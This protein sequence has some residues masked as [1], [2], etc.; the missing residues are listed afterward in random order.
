M[1]AR[2]LSSVELTLYRQLLE[3]V[4]AEMGRVLQHSSYSPNIKERRDFSC[5]LFDGAGHMVAQG[6]DI[7]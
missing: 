7:P 5:A 4:C 3:S 6:R 2:K 1:P